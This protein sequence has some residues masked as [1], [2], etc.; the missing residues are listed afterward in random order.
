MH[1]AV[2]TTYFSTRVERVFFRLFRLQSKGEHNAL[3]IIVRETEIPIHQLPV[4]L[5]GMKI[6]HI[7][8][9]HIDGS[10]KLYENIIE[11]IKPLCYDIAVM[12]GDYRFL[13]WGNVATAHGYL[14][15]IIDVMQTKSPVYG[16]L[17]NHDIFITAE[18]LD[19]LGVR[20]LMNE[21][22]ALRRNGAVLY[23]AGVDAKIHYNAAD[24]DAAL[25]GR[26]SMPVIL[27][28][29]SPML[30]LD[31]AVR[32]VDVYLCGH[33]H[34]GQI[35]LPGGI[36]LKTKVVSPFKTKKGFWKHKRMIGFTHAGLGSSGFFARF[37]CPPEI[38]IHTLCRA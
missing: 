22:V 28:A 27:L 19:S 38:V 6:L 14:K 18:Y 17:G 34:G 3:S 1:P 7:S 12:T 9:L 2:D 13:I 4:S 20:M 29:H 26:A 36:P 16:I 30:Y 15:H 37:H 8:D 21:G 32:N 31:A 23:L 10:P 24:I 25:A 35:C 11:K 33:T 5:D